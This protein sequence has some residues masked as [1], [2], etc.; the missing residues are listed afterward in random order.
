MKIPH[1][2]IDA[3]T[4]TPFGGNPASVC[5]LEGWLPERVMQDI[6]TENGESETAFIT[7]GRGRYEIRWFTP[8]CEIDLCGHATLASAYVVM[9]HLEPEARKVAFSS[10]SGPLRVERNG[11]VLL[12]DFPSRP[13]VQVAI[14]DD[15]A[16]ALGIRP[17]EAHK[18]RD[19][20]AVLGS[21]REVRSLAPDFEKLADIKDAMGVIVTAPGEDVD[22]VSRFFAPGVG[23]PEDPVTGSAHC[24]LIP[25]WSKRLGKK[26]LNA[27]QL[28]RRGGELYCEDLGDRVHIGGGAVLFAR[29]DI[30]IDTP[31]RPGR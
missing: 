27:R 20:M 17:L 1:Y 29:G 6:A 5:V 8:S 9:E 30:Y 4:R 7:G 16:C 14:G 19:L 22:F 15:L 13:P 24:T 18:A 21:A 3:F 25:Y 28:S 11:D 2:H 26:E 12:M 10:Q 31:Q 23:I